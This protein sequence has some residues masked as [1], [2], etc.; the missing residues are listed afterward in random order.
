MIGVTMTATVV[1][2]NG[3]AAVVLPG[4]PVSAGVTQQNFGAA[5]H[6]AGVA[7]PDQ[8]S[9]RAVGEGAPVATV[10]RG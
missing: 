8:T 4:Q 10:G 3:G 5:S 2:V 7:A 6:A 1:A 9:P